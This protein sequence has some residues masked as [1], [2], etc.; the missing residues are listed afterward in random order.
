MANFYKIG[1]G[2]PV[3]IP[4]NCT[5]DQYDAGVEKARRNNYLAESDWTQVTDNGMS[6]AKKN[7]WKTYRQD[8]R[9]L[10]TSTDPNNIT[11]PTKPE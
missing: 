2:S 11:W 10:D 9:D 6:S 7:K 4:D 1:N 3:I 8:L 5:Q